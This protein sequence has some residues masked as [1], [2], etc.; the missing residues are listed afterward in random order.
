MTAGWESVMLRWA[1]ARTLP[2][3]LI[4]LLFAFAS[5]DAAAQD[6]EHTRG[7]RII[8]NAGPSISTPLKPPPSVPTLTTPP[9]V[10]IAPPLT[11][12]PPSGV[13]VPT[14][15]LTPQRPEVTPVPRTELPVGPI[16]AENS[17][18]LSLQILPGDNLHVGEKITLRVSTKR[19]GYLLIVDIDAVGKVTQLYPNV[20][21][22]MMTPR[23]HDTANLIKPG[24][25]VR[26]PNPLNLFAGFQL[27]ACRWSICRT[28]RPPWSASTAPSAS[29][30]RW[31]RSCASP[32]RRERAVWSRHTGPSTRNSI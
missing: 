11:P 16:Q 8:D 1:A 28:C 5:L 23:N 12:S 15:N 32:R 17:A 6:D 27:V 13:S 29:C 3:G 25:P 24:Q 18:G 31:P 21:S 7:V 20:R 14:A 2:V 26:I 4:C 19:A 30:R 22:L 9:T 10:V